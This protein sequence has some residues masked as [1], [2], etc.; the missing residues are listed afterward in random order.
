[1]E[2]LQAK[3]HFKDQWIDVLTNE[4]SSTEYCTET[5]YANTQEELNALVHQTVLKRKGSDVFGGHRHVV[6]VLGI[7]GAEDPVKYTLSK[8][9]MFD[10]ILQN[11]V[12]ITPD[13][14]LWTKVDGSKV[15]IKY[16]VAINDCG[17]SGLDL[18]DAIQ[19]YYDNLRR[20]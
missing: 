15:R 1:M 13:G 12:T 2:Q 6:E 11:R 5:V 20:Q 17:M 4:I 7:D 3:V 8:E 16:T 14:S 18:E 9:E 10:F 19:Y